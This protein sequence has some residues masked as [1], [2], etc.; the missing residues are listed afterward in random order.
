LQVGKTYIE[1]CLKDEEE[2]ERKKKGIKI[3]FYKN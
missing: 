1:V 2:F 3:L